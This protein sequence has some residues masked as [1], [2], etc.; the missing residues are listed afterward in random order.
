MD[1]PVNNNC[2]LLLKKYLVQ[3]HNQITVVMGDI[4]NNKILGGE[5]NLGISS[6]EA[7]EINHRTKVMDRIKNGD[8]NHQIKDG[9][10]SHQ[11]KG[12]DSNLNRILVDG[13]THNR[14]IR[15]IGEAAADGDEFLLFIFLSF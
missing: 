11:I 5:T 12:G 1:K 10:I 7:G 6:K 4:R 9:G 8:S 14:T 15:K 2:I 13:V 3:I